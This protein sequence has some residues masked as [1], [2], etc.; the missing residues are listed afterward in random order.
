M[1]AYV[2]IERSLGTGRGHFV[3]I[4]Q[5]LNI[6]GTSEVPEAT[7]QRGIIE[8]PYSVWAVQNHNNIE[9]LEY[10]RGGN[11][12]RRNGNM[13]ATLAPLYLTALKTLR[14]SFSCGEGE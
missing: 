7:L 14:I 9:K 1:I 10:T 5:Q 11:L 12:Y 8:L 13:R 3:S 4:V 2:L 6:E